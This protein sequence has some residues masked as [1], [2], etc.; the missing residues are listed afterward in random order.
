MKSLDNSN[1]CKCLDLYNIQV[2]NSDLQL[3]EGAL[4]A[5]TQDHRECLKHILDHGATIDGVVILPET[6][7]TLAAEHGSVKCLE[8]LL[9][10][11]ASITTAAGRGHG[12]S[13]LSIS[14]AG[15]H[16]DCVELLLKNGAD[17]NRL[18]EQSETPLM[19]AAANNSP[20]CLSVLLNNQATVNARNLGGKTA[21]M[22]AAEKGHYACVETLLKE[23]AELDHRD[24]DGNT[25]LMLA[26]A[27]GSATTLELL[28]NALQASDTS[29]ILDALRETNQE[30]KTAFMLAVGS[31]HVECL[32]KLL[33]FQA[34]AFTSGIN[35]D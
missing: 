26:A 35:W 13:L 32:R 5:I 33:K 6:P 30:G 29:N 19:V 8:F 2:T 23:N 3:N 17:A 10:Q 21:I 18:D 14:A 4:R 20:S 31:G 28:L 11:G 25:G 24:K 7:V 12:R 1:R 22:L 9:Q 16:K 34:S 27:S 15:S